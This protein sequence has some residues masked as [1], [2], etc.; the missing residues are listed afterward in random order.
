MLFPF[1]SVL[2]CDCFNRIYRVRLR[3]INSKIMKNMKHKFPW[4]DFPSS[5]QSCFHAE[6]AFVFNEFWRLIKYINYVISLMRKFVWIL[7][8][9]INVSIKCRESECER[10]SAPLIKLSIKLA[11]SPH[12]ETLSECCK[13]PE[14]LFYWLSSLN[15]FASI[16]QRERSK[17]SYFEKYKSCIRN[18]IKEIL[19]SDRS[20]FWY[21]ARQSF[22]IDFPIR[23]IY[24]RLMRVYRSQNVIYSPSCLFWMLDGTGGINL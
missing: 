6:I 4:H 24:W 2:C 10:L 11:F 8:W 19:A 16:K 1:F 21:C 13:Q 23:H 14:F 22:S 18:D 12:K 17:K 20:R 5:S 9:N 7:D 3:N 15:E